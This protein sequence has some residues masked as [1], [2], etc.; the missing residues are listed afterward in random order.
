MSVYMQQQ[1]VPGNSEVYRSLQNRVLHVI[2]LVLEFGD[3]Y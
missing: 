3:L 2:I 1:K